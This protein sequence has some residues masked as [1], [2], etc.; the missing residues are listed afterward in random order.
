MNR[1][2]PVGC[3]Y[4]EREKRGMGGGESPPPC[5]QHFFVHLFLTFFMLASKPKAEEPNHK[6]RS[7]SR[8]TSQGVEHCPPVCADS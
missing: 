7:L 1:T 3:F 5:T 6:A 2:L 8:L 4:K